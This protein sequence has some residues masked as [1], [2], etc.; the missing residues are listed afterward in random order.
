MI[1]VF[2][3]KNAYVPTD[4]AAVKKVRMLS[5]QTRLLLSNH[6]DTL[7]Q[8]TDYRDGAQQR[9]DA[10][11]ERRKQLY[12]RR[13]YLTGAELAACQKSIEELTAQIDKLRQE[14]KLCRYIRKRTQ[15]VLQPDRPLQGDARGPEAEATEPAKKE[16]PE[17]DTAFEI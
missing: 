11:T 2:P 8:L 7:D 5:R 10:L 14:V 6:I 12:N 3:K 9:I 13:R 16:K 4:P 1:G 17:K 15:A